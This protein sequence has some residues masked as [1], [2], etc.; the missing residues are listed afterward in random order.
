MP[1]PPA[2][3]ADAS[4]GELVALADQCVQCGLCLPAC[5][6]YSL[7]RIEAESARGRIAVARAL[8]LDPA[9]ATPGAERHLDQCLGCRRCEA[10]CPAGV[11]YGP[12][13]VQARAGQRLRR[14]PGLRQRATEALAARPRLLGAVLAAYRV[15]WPL[16]P[17]GLRPLPRPRPATPLP[18]AAGRIARVALFSGCVAR[19]YESGLRSALARLCAPLGF[20]VE[21]PAGQG[22]CGTLHAHAG[23]IAAAG[24]LAARN[25]RA[26]SGFGHVLTL[27]SGCHEA[28]AD[29]L[30]G[31]GIVEDA[32]V[33]LARQS[34]RL[35][36]RETRLRVA[37]HVPCTQQTLARSG[38]AT[39]ALL[40]RV[41]G[42]EVVV[43]DA[44]HG[45]CGAAG[46]RMLADPGRADEFRA[47]LLE[48]LAASGASRLLSANIGCRLHLGNGTSLP[49]E[50]PLEFLAGCLDDAPR[51]GAGARVRA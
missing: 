18:P 21:V 7:E 29:A 46:T 20:E 35:R 6:T 42:L 48:Q 45:C 1:A 51:A 16:L 33:F 24:G 15:A 2:R 37:L 25:R 41:P 8:A 17:R 49:V 10:V 40:D 4:A 38:G 36:L 19:T 47:P 9:A 32:A 39:R 22:C 43:L 44:G 14:R 30:G 23:D 12:I 11:Q 50:H 26:F 13:L 31:P 5:P 28:V 27:A 34:G 3:P